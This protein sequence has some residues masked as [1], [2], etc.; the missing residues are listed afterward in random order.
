LLLVWRKL[1]NCHED[2]RENDFYVST[3]SDLDLY[4]LT[5]NLLFLLLVSWSNSPAY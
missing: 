2:M 1:I 3:L 5:S 4:C